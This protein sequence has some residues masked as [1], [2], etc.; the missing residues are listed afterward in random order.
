MQTP[1]KGESPK[2][3]GSSELPTPPTSQTNSSQASKESPAPTRTSTRKRRP[4]RN[5]SPSPPPVK[6]GKS[7]GRQNTSKKPS[8]NEVDSMGDEPSGS[9]SEENEA[10]TDDRSSQDISSTMSSPTRLGKAKGS[11]VI[12]ST[13]VKLPTRKTLGVS[14]NMN[15]STSSDGSM[16]V[17]RSSRRRGK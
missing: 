6:R 8:P 14:N 11:L 16:G 2:K 15:E 13:S 12:A 17:R 7:G 10:T 4:P 9:E 3:Q 5:L 1:V